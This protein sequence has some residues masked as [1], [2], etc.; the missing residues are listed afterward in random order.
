MALIPTNSVGGYSTGLT[1][2]NV[3]DAAGNITAVAGTFTGNFSGATGSFSKLLTASAGLSAS[4][5]TV[6]GGATFSGNV[7]ASRGN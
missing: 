3:I 6:A 1:M 7:S 5:L 4:A 2:T